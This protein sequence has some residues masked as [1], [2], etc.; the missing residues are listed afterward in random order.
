M[1][2]KIY[3][4]NGSTTFPKPTVV[5]DAVYHYMTRIGSN[6]NRGCYNNAYS[7]EEIVYQKIQTLSGK[8]SWSHYCELLT[9]SDADKR[10]FYE[11][12]NRKFKYPY[13]RIF[14]GK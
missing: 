5:A 11:K 14:A 3:L 6:I 10:S 7:I 9:I 4:D 8:L 1:N 13:Q 12:H 2:E